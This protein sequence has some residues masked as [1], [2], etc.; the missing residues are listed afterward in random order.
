MD[1]QSAQHIQLADGLEWVCRGWGC[2]WGRVCSTFH[3]LQQDGSTAASCTPAPVCSAPFTTHLCRVFRDLLPGTKQFP[4]GYSH[5][6]SG[7]AGAVQVPSALP[8]ISEVPLAVGFQLQSALAGGERCYVSQGRRA[9]RW[10]PSRGQQEW[11]AGVQRVPLGSRSAEPQTCEIKYFCLR[12]DRG[13]PQARHFFFS[14]TS[15][16]LASH[17]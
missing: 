13:A 2:I 3:S 6:A 1:L 7:E 15:L 11:G 8:K 5:L 9:P 16:Q 17:K 10:I 14:P 4:F 12:G